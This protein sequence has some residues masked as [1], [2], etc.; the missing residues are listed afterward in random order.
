MNV[1]IEF[2]GTSFTGIVLQLKPDSVVKDLLKAVAAEWLITADMIDV[3]YE[4]VV[5]HPET[6]DVLSHG[7]QG[8]SEL[9]IVEKERTIYCKNEWLKEGRPGEINNLFSTHCD[10]VF[11]VDAHSFKDEEDALIIGTEYLPTTLKRISFV[12]CCEIRSFGRCFLAFQQITT[13]DLVGYNN[14]VVISDYFLHSANHIETLSL[15]SLYNVKHIG[16]SFMDSCTALRDLDLKP[17]GQVQT[18]GSFFLSRVA[19]QSLNLSS[20]KNV[21]RLSN[22]FLYCCSSLVSV[23]LS[24]LC[25]VT[26][27]G[28]EFLHGCA[29]LAS[30]DLSGFT[31]LTSIGDSFLSGCKSLSDIEFSGLSHVVSIGDCFLRECTATINLPS[32]SSL[33]SVGRF[34]LLGCTSIESF[35]IAQFSRSMTERR[36]R[37]G[38]AALPNDS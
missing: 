37:C 19:C 16:D 25:N 38:R 23:D 2:P 11:T 7:V 34:F 24:G 14:V 5:L 12:N 21:K 1:S 4:G 30:I 10:R 17:L 18:I 15:S 28:N 9:M 27:I 35:D 8:D 3:S 13:C 20:F 29:S 33:I 22:Q 31:Q 6:S 32:L 26:C 36:E